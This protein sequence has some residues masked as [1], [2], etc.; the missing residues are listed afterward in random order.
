MTWNV[1]DPKFESD[2]IDVKLNITPWSTNRRFAYDLVRNVQPKTIVELGSHYGCSLFAF[3]QAAKDAKLKVTINGVDTWQGDEQ[4]GFYGEEIIEGVKKIQKQKF[5]SQK[6]NLIRKKFIEAL[7]DFEDGSIDL[8]HIDGLHTYDAVKED[9]DTW[10]P[11]LAKDGVMLFHD[12]TGEAAKKKYGSVKHWK[13]VSAKYPSLQLNHNWGLGILFPNGDKM[14]KQ[15]LDSGVDKMLP[16]YELTS[17]QEL[18]KNRLVIDLDWQ[19]EK[20]NEWWEK[21]M[22]FQYKLKQNTEK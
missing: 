4:A 3:A 19:K 17:M 20:T 8:I 11:K 6:I 18:Y 5:K 12:I 21:A 2:S 10:L 15:L 13:E 1:F 7:S 22:E 16:L 9:F 14:L